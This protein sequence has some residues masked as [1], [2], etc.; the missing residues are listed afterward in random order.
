MLR[1]S[2]VGK[3]RGEKGG[4]LSQWP[5]NHSDVKHDSCM[6]TLWKPE[7]DPLLSKKRSTFN[8]RKDQIK[9]ERTRS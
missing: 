5:L 2:P 6:G 1:L 7:I 3:Q 8:S 4:S 9:G